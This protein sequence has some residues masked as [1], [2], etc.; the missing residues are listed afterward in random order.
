M[1]PSSCSYIVVL[2]RKKFFLVIYFNIAF[3]RISLLTNTTI[4]RNIN[5]R[6]PIDAH[7]L[8]LLYTSVYFTHQKPAS[9]PNLCHFSFDLWSYYKVFFY[10]RKL[11]SIYVRPCICIILRMKSRV[12][13]SV[14]FVLIIEC[15]YIFQKLDSW[16][17][18]NFH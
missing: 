4:Y 12:H 5:S 8:L 9:Y 14:K 10:R 15:L 3:S 13:T 2:C 16:K 11:S 17:R 7:T 1:C 6:E 18:S